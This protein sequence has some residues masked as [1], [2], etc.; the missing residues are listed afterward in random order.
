MNREQLR[1]EF[2][3]AAGAHASPTTAVRTFT[4]TAGIN[5]RSR[6]HA[7]REILRSFGSIQLTGDR[8]SDLSTLGNAAADWVIEFAGEAA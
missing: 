1:A 2:I 6:A 7:V 5:P 8:T 4:T 3:A